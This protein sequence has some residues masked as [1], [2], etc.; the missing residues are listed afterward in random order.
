MKHF[1]TDSNDLYYNSFFSKNSLQKKDESEDEN[2]FSE[3]N[4]ENLGV[5]SNNEKKTIY[6]NITIL[7]IPSRKE[8]KFNK[9]KK[10]KTKEINYIH[11]YIDDKYKS[12]KKE[13]IKKVDMQ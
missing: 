10:P 8:E 12:D 9:C 7:S 3:S 1:L 5:S 4:F 11:Q 13:M 6:D 2:N